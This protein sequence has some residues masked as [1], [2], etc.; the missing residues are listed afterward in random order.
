MTVKERMGR[1][2]ECITAPRLQDK[3]PVV[4]TKIKGLTAKERAMEGKPV[5]REKGVFFF[6]YR[7]TQPILFFLLQYSIIPFKTIGPPRDGHY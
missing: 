7:K 3:K 5:R 4:R 2:K 1:I 6:L